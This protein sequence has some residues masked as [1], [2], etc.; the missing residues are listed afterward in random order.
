VE[1]FVGFPFSQYPA[2]L[3]YSLPLVQSECWVHFFFRKKNH[4]IKNP[5][6]PKTTRMIMTTIATFAPL[7]SA[8]F[9]FSFRYF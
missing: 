7:E 4:Q 9:K 1:P 2:A 3:Q 5:P 6:K 8:I